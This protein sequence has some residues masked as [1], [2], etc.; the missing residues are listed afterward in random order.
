MSRA[1]R[2]VVQGAAVAAL[3]TTLAFFLIRLAPGD[4]FA[5]LRENPNLSPATIDDLRTRFGFDQ[6]LVVQ[7]ARYV[8]RALHGDLGISVGTR[9]PVTEAIGDALPRT[10]LLMGVAIP[11]SFA[12]G[13]ALGVAQAARPRSRFDRITRAATTL[14]YAQ[15]SFLL[16]VV[17][18]L[19]FAA[20][21][22]LFQTTS[23]LGFLYGAG[24]GWA[25]FVWR[26][27]ELT[28]PVL[29]LVLLTTGA[30]ARQQRAALLE[31]LPEEFVRTAVAKGAAPRA[32]LLR[33]A[34][35]N[36]MLPMVTLLGLAF[37]AL[38][39][40]AVFVEQVFSWPG[41]GRLLVDAAATRDY[42]LLTGCVLVG[43][44]TVVV[45]S[46]LAD[47][48]ALLVDPRQRAS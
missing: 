24:S 44:V 20:W 43:S 21:L 19:V 32:V 46:L 7:Y 18:L 12:A 36:A 38:L 48:L 6:P 1:L 45:G 17:L 16:A 23:G 3:V 22:G 30:V 15:P 27:R 34:L 13:M 10:L 9:R 47:L 4:P 37:P 25:G 33:H 35:R 14:L 42:F 29:T 40:G 26:V 2:R 11:L 41:M 28:L 39:G 8:R 31:V 5:T